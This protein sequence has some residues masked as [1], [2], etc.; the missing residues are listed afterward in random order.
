MEMKNQVIVWK[1]CHL[2]GRCMSVSCEHS[3]LDLSLLCILVPNST[4]LWHN[5][6]LG[7]GWC[8]GYMA[9]LVHAGQCNPYGCY[10]K[11][12]WA[13]LKFCLHGFRWALV[14]LVSNGK[15]QERLGSFFMFMFLHFFCLHWGS[16]SRQIIMWHIN[17]E[18]LLNQGL[19][20]G[21]LVWYGGI[22]FNLFSCLNFRSSW[23]I[24]TICQI[25]SD[26]FPWQNIIWVIYIYIYI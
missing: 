24:P 22:I 11:V 4:F 18:F 10:F 6:D 13:D 12:R 20:V 2:N 19:C 21:F 23:D 8:G 3:Q 15:S 1:V 9:C 16:S 26:A 14:R 25:F 7:W 5:S 17:L